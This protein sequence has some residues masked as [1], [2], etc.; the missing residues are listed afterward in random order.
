MMNYSDGYA[1]RGAFYGAGTGPIW[2][3]RILCN[4]TEKTLHYCAHEGFSEKE[5]TEQTSWMKCS[6]H[7][8]DASVYCVDKCKGIKF[9][10]FLI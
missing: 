6:S 3:S 9:V 1:L 8:D 7:K 10:M 4:G 2:M 5:V